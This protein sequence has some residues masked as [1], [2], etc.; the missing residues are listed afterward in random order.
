MLY[1]INSD[2]L[3]FVAAKFNILFNFSSNFYRAGV[4]KLQSA[5]L[6]YTAHRN[7]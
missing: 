1:I 6:S 7:L 2:F 5:A 3:E 4:D